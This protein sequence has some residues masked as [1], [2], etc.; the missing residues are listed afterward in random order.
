[1]WMGIAL[2]YG[3][4]R[5]VISL[6]NFQCILLIVINYFTFNEISSTLEIIAAAIGIAGVVV[7]SLGSEIY[8]LFR[9]LS[10]KHNY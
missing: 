8:S 5:V 4:A 7:I 1:M 3:K 2:M 9:L 10:K 6:I